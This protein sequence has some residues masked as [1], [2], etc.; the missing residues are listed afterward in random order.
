VRKA[1]GKK[2]KDLTQRAQRTAGGHSS[3][4]T[5]RWNQRSLGRAPS[6]ATAMA[7][8]RDKFTQINTGADREIR[9]DGDL[10]AP[11]AGDP[12][13]IPCRVRRDEGHGRQQIRTSGNEGA[14]I[15][16]AE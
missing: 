12:G 5:R 13:A 9:R 8:R 16:E 1:N 3:G 6:F 7:G 4:R 10:R 14:G 15:M 2:E 11:F